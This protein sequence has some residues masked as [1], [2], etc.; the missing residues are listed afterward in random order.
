MIVDFHT[1]FD[2]QYKKLT[3]P[4]QK[5]AKSALL[6][7]R[8]DPY[9]SSLRNHPLKGE[10]APYRSISAGGDLRLHYRVIDENRA[11][12]VSVGTHS[13]LYK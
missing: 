6:I 5:R 9:N 7:F 1:S 10:L 8:Q 13:Q 3:T 11:L 12:F 4:Q 2:K